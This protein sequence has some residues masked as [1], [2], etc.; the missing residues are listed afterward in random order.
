MNK[1]FT[2]EHTN[3]CKGIAII[4]MVIHHLYWNS[5]G[6]GIY[7]GQVTLSQRIAAIGKVCVSI[8]LLL[9]GFGLAKTLKGKLEIKHFYFERLL[10]LYLNYTFIVITSIIISLV[11]FREEYSNLVGSGLKEIILI[12]L[13]LSGLQYFI[14]YQGLNGAWWFM[15]VILVFYLLFPFIK[16]LIEKY[17]IKFVVLFFIIS[18]LDIVQFQHIKI[19]TI[20]SWGFPFVLGIYLAMN[21]IFIKIYEYIISKRKGA[22]KLILIFILIISLIV[23]QNMDPQSFIGIKFDYFLAFIIVLSIYIFYQNIVIGK[24]II[25]FLGKKSSD[26]YYLH[27]FISYYYLYDLIY[28]MNNIFFMIISVIAFSLIWSLV[29]EIIRKIIKWDEV[30]LYCCRYVKKVKGETWE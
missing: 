23:K 21:N 29:L 9:S 5:P 27:M 3:Y 1:D 26:I 20:I 2:V 11:F 30:I 16:I 12:I 25:C 17:K 7:I 8:F 13:N 6:Y 24:K 14:G 10:K 22:K 28:S 19:V 15:S 4:L 18:C